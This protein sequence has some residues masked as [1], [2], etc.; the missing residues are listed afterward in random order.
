MTRGL[1]GPI[2]GASF[3][4]SWTKIGRI[5]CAF[6]ALQNFKNVA[7]FYLGLFWQPALRELSESLLWKSFQRAGDRSPGPVDEVVEDPS[8]CKMFWNWIIREKV[9]ILKL[10]LSFKRIF[11]QFSTFDFLV[12][13]NPGGIFVPRATLEV[14]KSQVKFFV[15]YLDLVRESSWHGQTANM[16]QYMWVY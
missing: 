4:M 12:K 9:Y 14:P 11:D 7:P 16:C 3:V 2:F 15:Q 13:S 1:A 8:K 5:W 10:N 6:D